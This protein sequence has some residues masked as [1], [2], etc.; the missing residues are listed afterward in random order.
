MQDTSRA[1]CLAVRIGAGC[2]HV[3]PRL[4]SM[5]QSKQT[6]ATKRKF[7]ETS[8]IN[9]CSSVKLN[10]QVWEVVVL[11]TDVVDLCCN[12]EHYPDSPRHTV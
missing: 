11:N 9:G 3:D 4:L 6:T 7:K 2:I 5:P 10:G 1:P 12:D 8:R